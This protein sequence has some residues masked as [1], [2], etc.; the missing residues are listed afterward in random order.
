MTLHA[1]AA[2]RLAI[3][4]G[5]EARNRLVAI[6]RVGVPAL[7]AVALSALLLQIYMSSQTARFGISQIV[8][9]PDSISVETPEYSGVLDDGTAYRVSAS[10]ARAAVEATDRI[11][12]SDASLTM[13]KPDGVTIQVDTPAAVLDTTGQIVEIEGMAEVS[14][15]LGTS[16]VLRNTVFDYVAQRLTGTGK[17]DIDY[18]DGTK[19]LAEG[20]TYD[21]AAMVWTFTRA[22]VTLPDTPGAN[23]PAMPTP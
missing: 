3:Y 11:G 12:L 14:N 23:Q 4:R 1:D 13:V 15:S 2:Q 18:A 8:V 19:L 20:L 5:L 22:T 16:G 10:S 7:G 9:S 6:L 21:A 17:V